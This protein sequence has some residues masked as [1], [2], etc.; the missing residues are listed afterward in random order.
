MITKC[1]TVFFIQFSI[2]DF[3]FYIVN[4]GGDREPTEIKEFKNADYQGAK[5]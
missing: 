4:T 1:L 2:V 5:N 3:K